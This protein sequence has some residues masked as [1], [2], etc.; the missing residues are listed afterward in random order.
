MTWDTVQQL[1]RI[2]LQIAGGWLMSRGYITE[3]MATTLTGS[4][5]SI[6]GVLWWIAWNGARPADT[7]KTGV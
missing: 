7:S 5:L 6:G 4:L 2:I 3:E 1:V